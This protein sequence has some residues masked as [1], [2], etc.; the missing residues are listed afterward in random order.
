[1]NNHCFCLLTHYSR[2]K[3]QGSFYLYLV[4][5]MIYHNHYATW[6]PHLVY[7]NSWAPGI[8]IVLVFVYN[9]SVPYLKEN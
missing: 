2:K 5:G 4:T 1:M 8:G 7:L 6:L 3:N 9:I